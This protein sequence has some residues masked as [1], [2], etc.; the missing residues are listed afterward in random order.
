M[1]YPTEYKSDEGK[2]YTVSIILSTVPSTG[3]V[4]SRYFSHH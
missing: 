4:L 1:S 2:V 3:E